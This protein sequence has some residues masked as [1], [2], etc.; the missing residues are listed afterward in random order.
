[1]DAKTI[2]RILCSHN[3]AALECSVDAASAG[4]IVTALNA[5]LC[6]ENYMV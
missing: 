5:A 2:L 6:N 4:D 1:M 3:V